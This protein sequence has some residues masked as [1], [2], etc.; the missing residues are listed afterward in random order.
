MLCVVAFCIVVPLQSGR[1]ESASRIVLAVAFVIIA[2]H[3]I[4]MA[5]H[6]RLFSSQGRHIYTLRK[7]DYPYCTGPEAVSV[8]IGAL[9][10]FLAG[11]YVA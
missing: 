2:F 4:C 11:L 3:P 8:V 10:A 5:C 7:Q 6:Y 1:F 9:L